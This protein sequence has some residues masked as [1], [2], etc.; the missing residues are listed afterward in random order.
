[1]TKE[2]ATPKLVSP[3]DLAETPAAPN[4][5]DP[6]FLRLDQSFFAGAGVKRML[7]TIPTRKP[8][9]QDWV[10]V[11]A[12]PQYRLP[13]AVIELKDDREFYLLPPPIAEQLPG[14]YVTVVLFVAINR[15]GTLFLWPV[16]L[17]GADGK[18]LEWHRSA[19]AP[20]RSSRPA[21][22]SPIPSGPS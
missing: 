2:G 3:L 5:F 14:E 4:P 1:M 22:R 18:V 20:T 10:R 11:N 13:I 8:G 17:P 15:Q 7:T 6:E 9:P 21:P 19:A 12:D 16:K